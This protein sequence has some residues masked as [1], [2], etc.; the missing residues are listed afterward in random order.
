M[1]LGQIP[2]NALVVSFCRGPCEGPTC[3]CEENMKAAVQRNP[4]RPLVILPNDDPY[5]AAASNRG[6]EK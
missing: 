3:F 5:W 2:D 6:A 4:G 1:T